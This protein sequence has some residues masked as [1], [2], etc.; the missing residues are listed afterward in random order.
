MH[1]YTLYVYSIHI[2]YIYKYV[3][4]N[5]LYTLNVSIYYILSMYLV[6]VHTYIYIR[7]I[8]ILYSDRKGKRER[9]TEY[10]AY[11]Y[12]HYMF[13]NI[14]SIKIIDCVFMHIIFSWIFFISCQGKT[15][16]Y[17]KGLRGLD[18]KIRCS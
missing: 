8:Y 7:F 14:Y 6:Y 2:K 17:F 3:F 16:N 11:F 10:I 9:Y 18:V 1:K 13:A 4:Y 15:K 5:I 12:I